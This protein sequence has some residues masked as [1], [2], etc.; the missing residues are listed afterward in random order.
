[1]KKELRHI[2]INAVLLVVYTVVLLIVADTDTT[3]AQNGEQAKAQRP[4]I[5]IG[6]SYAEEAAQAAYTE[7]T[8]RVV[9]TL[10]LCTRKP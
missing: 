3:Q 7:P 1:M 5:Y 9:F 10:F 8:A 4:M 6:S 2:K